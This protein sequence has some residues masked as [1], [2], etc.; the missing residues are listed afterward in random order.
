[1]PSIHVPTMMRR[2]TDNERSVEVPGATVAA[3]LQAF[4]ERYPQ[5]LGQIYD[6]GGGLKSFV[7]IFVNDT[8]IRSLAGKDTPLRE[9]DELHIIPAIAGG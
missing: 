4:E 7:A 2:F 5:A 1:M 6:E 9:N 3:A 8:D